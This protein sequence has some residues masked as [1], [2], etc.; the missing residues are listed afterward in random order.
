MSLFE[1]THL[2]SDPAHHTDCMSLPSSGLG[3]MLVCSMLH[4]HVRCHLS[5]RTFSMFFVACC[6]FLLASRSP[7]IASYSA[8]HRLRATGPVRQAFPDL[9]LTQIPH[10][11]GK[12]VKVITSTACLVTSSIFLFTTVIAKFLF[13]SRNDRLLD[14]FLHSRQS[15]A[16]FGD[17]SD[18]CDLLPWCAEEPVATHLLV[19]CDLRRV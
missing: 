2:S 15:A 4:V 5:G 7:I 11:I 3:W 10:S 12:R 13:P 8:L 9:S 6:S 16:P 1:G 14:R 17:D 19:K 18:T